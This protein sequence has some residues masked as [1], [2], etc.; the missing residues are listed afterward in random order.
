[1]SA[2][3][4][5]RPLTW[6]LEELTRRPLVTL[7]WGDGE[8]LVAS[9]TRTGTRFQAQEL[10]TPKLEDRLR[11]A[12]RW[13]DARGVFGTDPFLLAPETY[14]GNDV[15]TVTANGRLARRV[16]EETGC[17]REW[18]DATVWDVTVREGRLG[19][20]VRWLRGKRVCVVSN[21]RVHAWEGWGT[22]TQ[23]V[24]VPVENAAD[25]QDQTYALARNAGRG[26]DAFVVCCGISAIPLCVD[27]ARRFPSASVFDLGSTFDVFVGLGKERG[28]RRE[29]YADPAALADLRRRNLEDAT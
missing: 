28:W 4:H 29:L 24:P 2:T 5:L 21:P 18:H 25:K 11:A 20:F 1:M 14:P 27:L 13:T 22:G 19:P 9:K 8:F 7:T 23:F 16:L 10:S 15:E 26:C 3:I 17:T 6:Y 12:L